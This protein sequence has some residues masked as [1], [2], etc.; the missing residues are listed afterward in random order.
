MRRNIPPPPPR[1]LSQRLYDLDTRNNNG[2]PPPPQRHTSA[3]DEQSE[4]S[5]NDS[6]VAMAKRLDAGSVISDPSFIEGAHPHVHGMEP[7]GFGEST[8]T[9]GQGHPADNMYNGH[10][11][12]SRNNRYPPPRDL[13][14]IASAETDINS[15]YTCDDDDSRSAY[16]AESMEQR[17]PPKPMPPPPGVPM[18]GHHGRRVDPRLY[19]TDEQNRL[20][21]SISSDR[22]TGQM[23]RERSRSP[24]GRSKSPSNRGRRNNLNS[25][26]SNGSSQ[27]SAQTRRRA[28][29]Q[30]RDDSDR[31]RTRSQSPGSIGSIYS[32]GIDRVGFD[33][34]KAI[35]IISIPIMIILVIAVGVGVAYGLRDDGNESE[36]IENQ[37]LIQVSIPTPSPTYTGEYNCP[38][39]YFGPVPT[40]GCTGYVVCNGMGEIE[41]DVLA[42]PSGTLYDAN[43][44]TCGWAANVDCSTKVT[45][46]EDSTDT[47]IDTTT[48]M[49]L[50]PS[51][52]V[53]DLTPITSESKRVGPIDT[54]DHK[55]S[56]RGVLTLGDVP[57]FQKNLEIYINIFYSPSR[58]VVMGNDVAPLANNDPILNNVSDVKVELTVTSF[59]WSG[60]TRGLR[61]LQ[62]NVELIMIFDQKTEYL[63]TDPTIKV[64]TIVRHPYE[65]QYEIFLIEYL[66]STDD[67][68]GSL[69]SVDF[70]E[71]GQTINQSETSP[72]TSTPTKQP[73]IS[74]PDT[75]PP[76]VSIETPSPTI[77]TDAPTLKP[78]PI[79]TESVFLA[80][81][82]Y[83]TVQ[84]IMWIDENE[85]G[86]YE[87]SEPPAAG[88][89]ANLR[90]CDDKWVQTTSS[91]AVG[92]YQFLGVTEGEYY[93]EFFR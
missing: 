75:V 43:S 33:K 4:I 89:F 19:A 58:N 41:G 22:Y 74:V 62:D 5:D 81:P 56:F 54:F 32:D 46:A 51:T 39:G 26:N 30:T 1:P 11:N 78:T 16:T 28:R 17:A 76:T 92:Q 20:D 91:N 59:E 50:S 34:I 31:I 44:R 60:T 48:A 38:A 65:E 90:Q 61:G 79:P 72:P 49:T 69:T 24:G 2:R 27:S 15:V 55:L 85:N 80:F 84:G 53:I 70:L 71:P 88:T 57:T 8:S 7:N 3:D 45:T 23:E 21:N 40:K 18:V 35:K 68:F 10:N 25:R 42:C 83:Y 86:L 37:E 29:S 63:T 77:M 52:S 64:G 6:L 66:K 12:N 36:R 13:D 87:S 93:V 73:V 9:L 47:T 14:S 82:E 67:V